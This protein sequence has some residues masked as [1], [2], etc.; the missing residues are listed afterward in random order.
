M[1]KLWQDLKQA[2][3]MMGRAP[4]VTVVAI[5]TIALGIGANT[6]IFS[7]VNA[8][9]LRPLPGRDPGRL[10]T[11]YTADFSGPLYGA[12]SY[13]DYL[14]FRDG[15]EV[16]SGLAAYTVQPLLV[17]AATGDSF[18]VLGEAATANYFDVLGLTPLYGR[19]FLPAEE[20]NPGQHAVA[21]ISHG[22]WQRRFGADP[23]VVNSKIAVNGRAFTV[24]GVAREGMA[25]LMRGVAV[26]V[27][28][29]MSM[30]PV[31]TQRPDTLEQR[32]SRGYFVIGRLKPGVTL[33][34]ARANMSL[35]GQQLHAEYPDNWRN[36]LR[37]PR[38]VSVLPESASRVP[39]FAREPVTMFLVLLLSVV[40][41]VLL[42]ACANVANLQLSR[43][44]A[45]RREMAIRV[46]LGAR[47]G[48]ILR[49]LLTES[50]LLALAAGGVA[51]LIA[52]WTTSLLMN[53]RP[54]TPVPV[55]LDLGLDSRVLLFTLGISMLTG[56]LF[57]LAPALRAS[58]P[59]Q[60]QALKDEGGSVGGGW[61]RGHM[62]NA[63]V[64]AQVSLSLLLLIASGL[65]L[66]SLA[67]AQA[68]DPG[69]DSRNVLLFDVDLE[70]SGY[71]TTRG[72]NFFRELQGRLAALPSAES[73]TVATRLPL[74]LQ[75]SRGS[76]Q[77][78]G[79]QFAEGE[80]REV[81]FSHVGPGYFRALRTPL[82]M[83][84]EFQTSD[85]PESLQVVIVNEA[86]V[87]RYWPGQN[88]LGKHITRA[89]RVGGEFQPFVLEVV[90][91][92][93]DGKYNSLGEEP[94]PYIFYPHSQDYRAAVTVALR[95]QS[96]PTALVDAARATVRSLDASL[97]VFNVRT[98]DA[99]MGIALL[100]VRMAATL[101]GVMGG[102]A[103]V[104]A[105][106]GIYGVISF[107]VSQRTREIGVRMALG[108]QRRDILGLVLRSGMT[109]T[110]IGCAI[111]L[112][113]AAGVTRF[114]TFLLYGISPLDPVTFIGIPALL[115]GVA[116]LACWIP[117]RR[118]ARVDPMVALRY[119]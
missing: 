8:V 85:T 50:L 65:F 45:R 84:R 6:T 16:F 102:L 19:A 38:Q 87:R 114:L 54:P 23:A 119:E 68:I 30:Q 3:R 106:V 29:P 108:A 47:R 35:I 28:T 101:L 1:E 88:P 75:W 55:A 57:G 96:E 104:L 70:P 93:R 9:L 112:A 12:S 31:I 113:A 71:D 40:G 17:T 5:I 39:P 95:T 74:D 115:A 62:R 107:A 60:V 76:V 56:I 94:T 72:Q 105:A 26:D 20:S 92:A 110:L 48:Q 98:L 33:E 67:N 24:I 51:I 25:G 22:L 69:F 116:L 58:R 14:D 86:F 10:A 97:P 73:A 34:Q 90:G 53:F 64:V 42:I 82:V 63:L 41:L 66:R 27:W 7:L 91:L 80:D 43:A 21:M 109:L 52:L 4:G 59:E 13:P 46:A 111:G 2:A 117:A 37:E 61:R 118:A 18:R 83:G 79:Y 78:E 103:L 44:I 11:V 89:R 77:I 36:R 32:G 99:Q 100:P 49:Q 81:R 15:N